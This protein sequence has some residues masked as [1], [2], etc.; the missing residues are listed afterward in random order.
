MEVGFRFQVDNPQP[1]TQNPELFFTVHNIL[2]ETTPFTLTVDAAA[3]G[4]A[5]PERL[6][7]AELVSGNEVQHE[8]Q[9]DL[10]LIW[11]ELA[12]LD[13]VV[14]RLEEGLVP[15]TLYLP[16]I[17]KTGVGGGSDQ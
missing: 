12:P 6:T 5:N 10:L 17:Q 15:N 3:L 13:T 8:V 7:V 2:T 11:G 16:L 14:F 9:G 4:I 1:E